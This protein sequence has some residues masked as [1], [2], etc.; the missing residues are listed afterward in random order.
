[1]ARDPRT[2]LKTDPPAGFSSQAAFPGPNPAGGILRCLS[3]VADEALNIYDSY[4]AVVGA[5]PRGQA[6]AAGQALGA[7]NLLLANPAGPVLLQRRRSGQENGGLWDKSVGGHVGAGESFD[8][9]VVREAGEELF[10]DPHSA[11]A[12]L[13]AD[14]TDY[15]AQASA[16]ALAGRV[17]FRR[18]GLRLNLRDVRRLP[19][20]RHRN[21]LYHV[22]V[23]LGRTDL[24]LPAFRPQ[25]SEVTELAYLAPAAVDALLLEGGLAPNMAF[26]WLAHAHTLLAP[27]ASRDGLRPPERL[28]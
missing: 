16:G 13:A 3:K 27:L 22:A 24:P 2:T 5:R 8:R 26:L 9:T 6:L 20:G 10:D 7:V 25:R 1:V 11:K 21:V 19:G 12:V 15:H 4:G 23:Y 14:E 28:P 17:V 18:A